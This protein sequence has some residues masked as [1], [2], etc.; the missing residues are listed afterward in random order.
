MN[1]SEHI[2]SEQVILGPGEPAPRLF[3]LPRKNEN[4]AVWNAARILVAFLLVVSPLLFGA[5][6]SWAWGG[7]TVITV[8]LLMLWIVGGVRKASVRVMWSPLLIPIL[9]T[10]AICAMQL[11]SGA[12]EDY[13]GTREALLKLITYAVLFFVTQQLYFSAPA[14]VWR[15]TGIT[16]A[17]YTFGIAFF[18]VAQFLI[19]PGLVYGKLAE[20]N[21]VFGPYVNHGDYAGL[22]EMLIPL[23]LGFALGLRWKHPAKPLVLFLVLI[24]V[25][26]VFLSGSRAG[27]V[28]LAVEF[29]I[30]A[31]V[32]ISS[33]SNQRQFVVTGMAGI[34][35]AVGVFFWLDPGEVWGRWQQMGSRPELALGNRQV[36]ALDTLRMTREHLVHG[37]GLGA[38][39]TAYSPYQT[40][41]T[42]LSIDY[43]HNDYLQ[44]VAETG[45]CGMMVLVTA[46]T[47]FFLL[48]FRH[49]RERLQDPEGWLQ[50]GAAVGVCGLLVHSFSEFNLHI[51]ANAAWFTFSAA[52]ATLP[53][54]HKHHRRR[55]HGHA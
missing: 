26:S 46:L 27:L 35:L 54:A 19:S 48:A 32:L 20:S 37:V 39:Q 4:P 11:V 18:A 38:F 23:T 25:V 13:T 22:M 7:M 55:S 30:V 14:N 16:T 44:F 52:L 43:A 2:L 6:Q 53:I 12:S 17:A 1:T 50:L 33:R 31:A 47:F 49:L 10:V 41:A 34:C 5:V 21:S 8:V 40:V 3:T 28:S 45:I 24:G 42:D 29:A 15:I 51:P 9:A 36:I